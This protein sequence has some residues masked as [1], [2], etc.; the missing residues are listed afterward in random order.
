MIIDII[1]LFI[2]LFSAFKGWKNGIIK[3]VFYFLALFVG[4]VAALKLSSVVAVY[5]GEH[6]N[7]GGAWLPVL[8]FLIVFVATAFLIRLAANVIDSLAK[9][10]FLG[11][12]NRLSGILFYLAIYMIIFSVL[13][14]YIQQLNIFSPATTDASITYSF[15]RDLGPASIDGIGKAFPFV[16]GMFHDLSSF[17]DSVVK[18]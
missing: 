13:L 6:T 15:I 17:F 2:V 12:F 18:K 8:A 7:I 16:K 9:K 3:A 1:V 11:L 5:L 10:V 14:F 4:L